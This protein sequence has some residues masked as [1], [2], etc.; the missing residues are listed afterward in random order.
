MQRN[1]YR[2]M[3]VF[4]SG[5]LISFASGEVRVTLANGSAVAAELSRYF[6][7]G[8]LHASWQEFAV[9]GYTRRITGVVYR[10]HPRPTCGM[11]LGGLDT[12]CIDIEPNGLLG[13]STLFNQLV[14]PRLLYNVPFLGLSVDGHACVLASDIRAK[15]QRPVHN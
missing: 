11:P 7:G 6:P 5:L 14:N 9:Q 1:S 3:I 15:K 8:V 4:V 10:G 2:I 12:G 13:Y